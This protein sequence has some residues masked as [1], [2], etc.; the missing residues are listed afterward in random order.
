M[1]ISFQ[2]VVIYIEA[3]KGFKLE[4]GSDQFKRWLWLQWFSGPGPLFLL[5][6]IIFPPALVEFFS[7]FSYATIT[8]I[9]KSYLYFVI[10]IPYNLQ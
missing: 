8:S 4:E 1:W 2:E 10:C 6:I 9:P 7:A 3:L 5:F